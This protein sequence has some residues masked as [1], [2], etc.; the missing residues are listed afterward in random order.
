MKEKMI[1]WYIFIVAQK[2][3]CVVLI[4]ERVLLIIQIPLDDNSF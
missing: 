1:T 2:L 4:S 3:A